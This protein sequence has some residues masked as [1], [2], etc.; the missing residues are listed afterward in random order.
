MVPG[1]ANI[2]VVAGGAVEEVQAPLSRVTAIRRTDIV[3]ITRRQPGK[4]AGPAVAMV[5]QG[6]GVAVRTGGIVLL[7]CT[8]AALIT[9]IVGAGVGIIAI[10]RRASY[11]LTI[12]ADVA[13]SARVSVRA[14]PR[15][16]LMGATA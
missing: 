7:M 10:Q 12:D 16:I 13:H 11:A 8:L 5:P 9:G 1:G 3:V 4:E 2:P 6:T 14:H 15:Q